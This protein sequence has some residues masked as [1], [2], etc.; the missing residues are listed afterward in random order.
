MHV[1]TCACDIVPHRNGVRDHT[2]VCDRRVEEDDYG[3]PRWWVATWTARGSVSNIQH[4]HCH[5][6]P[7]SS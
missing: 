5:N 4:M 6:Q 1:L 7:I 2:H 3:V